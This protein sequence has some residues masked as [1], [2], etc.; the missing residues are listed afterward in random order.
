MTMLSLTA[1][2]SGRT[3]LHS[4]PQGVSRSFPLT[5]RAKQINAKKTKRTDADYAELADLEVLSR[6]YFDPEIG[7]YA[8]TR[9]VAEAVA[10][11]AFAVAKISKATVR[12]ALFMRE[13]KVPMDYRGKKGVTVIEDI[14]KNPAFRH[15]MI[16]PQGQIRIEKNSPIFHDWSFSVTMDFDDKVFDRAD[17]QRIIEETA[18]YVGFGDFRP[19]FGRAS[20]EFTK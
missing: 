19:T 20:V 13:D 16:L 18:Q 6:V 12:G 9:W 17:L 2:F 11:K 1:K 3:L 14:V 7:V 10:R 15:A 8:P 4:N 5:R